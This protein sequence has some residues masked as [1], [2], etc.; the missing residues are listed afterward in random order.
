MSF[1]SVVTRLL[2]SSETC[3]SPFRCSSLA[4]PQACSLKSFNSSCV[5]PPFDC[6]SVLPLD[7]DCIS[8]TVSSV[9][10]IKG[11]T[12]LGSWTIRLSDLLGFIACSLLSMTSSLAMQML[13]WRWAP[14]SASICRFSRPAML[15][16][17]HICCS[18]SSACSTSACN[19][20]DKPCQSKRLH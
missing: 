12:C 4:Q 1:S 10:S 14:A 20:S 13:S 5:L 3:K 8:G 16:R 7:L 2:T 19:C 17:R 11:L 6:S 9:F 18:N 15:A